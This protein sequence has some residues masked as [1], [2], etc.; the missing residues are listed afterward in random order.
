MM[1]AVAFPLLMGFAFGALLQAGRLADSNVVAGQFSLRDSTMAKALLTAILVGGLGVLVLIGAGDAVYYV[2]DAN[3][4][5]VGL[6][7]A[8]FGVAL[9][10]LGYCPGT[11]IAAV[12]AGSLHALAGLAGMIFGAVLYALSF[13][14]VK[15]HVLPVWA[16]GKLRLPGLTGIPD[17][18]WFAG[19]AIAAG[20]FFVAL[21]SRERGA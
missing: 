3:L 20:L 10:V 14:W 17:I 8:M 15:A 2:K 5:A 21:E 16:F 6:G 4:L 12:G 7:A 1:F 18:Y 13:D 11:M 9:A 19:L